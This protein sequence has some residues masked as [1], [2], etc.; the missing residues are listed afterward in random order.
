MVKVLKNINDLKRIINPHIQYA[1]KSTQKIIN[2]C[3]QESIDEYY[4]EKVFL[5][6]TSCIP[7]VYDRTYKLLNSLVKTEIVKSGDTFSCQVKIDDNYLNYRYPGTIGLPSQPATG[8][9]ILQW[10]DKDGSHGGTIDGNWRIWKQAIT[11]IGGNYGIISIFRS[12]LKECGI[13][14]KNN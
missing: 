2:D 9:D 12:K 6:G 4:K 5:D 14:V 7:D 3:I 8:R 10:N 11:S 13:Y 1:L